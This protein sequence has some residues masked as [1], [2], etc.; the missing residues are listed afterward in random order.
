M[1]YQR[2][3]AQHAAAFAGSAGERAALV[4]NR[5]LEIIEAGACDLEPVRAASRWWKWIGTPRPRRSGW[6]RPAARPRRRRRGTR[7][8]GNWRAMA[9]AV[10][11][12]ADA[13]VEDPRRCRQVREAV[14][15]AARATSPHVRRRP[16]ATGALPTMRRRGAEIAQAGA[17]VVRIVG[18]AEPAGLAMDLAVAD[19]GGGTRQ[20]RVEFQRA[21]APLPACRARAA[22][23]SPA[24]HRVVASIA[25]HIIVCASG[26]RPVA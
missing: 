9:C 8:P 24:T 2:H 7:Q 20:R 4:R 14:R 19:V 6:P 21:A 25:S 3:R 1:Q 17:D 18:S 23:L 12:D 11:P 22:T 16:P 5:M 10:Q 26:R 13:Q 15:A